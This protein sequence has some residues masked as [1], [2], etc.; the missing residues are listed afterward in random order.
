MRKVFL[1]LGLLF[2]LAFSA[3]AQTQTTVTG[4][5]VD[6]A[7]NLATS[8]YVTFTIKPAA[9]SILYFVLNINVIAP[10]SGQCGINSSGQVM[11]VSNPANPCLVWGNDV[12]TPGNTTYTVQFFPNGIAGQLI[13][14]LLITGT[15]YSLQAPVFTPQV[16][17]NPQQTSIRA[18]PFQTNI[19]PV[20][21]NV[22]NIGS[23]SYRFA[24]GYFGSLFA[25]NI[26]CV[27]TCGLI[28]SFAS[29]NLSPLFTTTVTNPSGPNVSQSFTASTFGGH[30][31]YGNNTGGTATPGAESILLPDVGPG[32][33]PTGIFDWS[34][35][36]KTIMHVS[37]SY[38]PSVNG[39]VGFDT[40][41]GLLW[42]FSTQDLFVV[43]AVIPTAEHST[44]GVC[45]T[46]GAGTSST[47]TY[48]GDG[49]SNC[50]SVVGHTG[51]VLTGT[52]VHIVQDT[53]VLGTSCSVTLSGT[54]VFTSS[55]S[56]TCVAADNTATD[57]VEVTQSSG[58][59]VVFTG[60][61]TDTLRYICVGD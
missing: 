2:G 5:V 10:V 39:E 1:T 49:L 32:V 59:A 22:F 7:G 35:T 8:G 28:T 41:T 16:Q 34:G 51:T 24:A 56:Y 27:S 48:L 3:Q 53:C 14:Q 43:P 46:W 30:K 58:T 44:A 57:P 52:G 15:T 23:P 50:L 61:G 38:V 19:I 6:P 29:G 37:S 55:T 9:A 17:I 45:A 54:A 11:S 26:Q 21:D 31:W 47:S 4:T 40:T 13:N 20:A 12:I 60:T 42:T 33:A 36:T 18:N 25:T